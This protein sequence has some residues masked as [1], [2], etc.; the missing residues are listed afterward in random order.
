MKAHVFV[1]LKF[2]LVVFMVLFLLPINVYSQDLPEIKAAGVL[3]HLGIPYANFVTGSGDG[4]DIEVIKGFATYLGVDYQF[5]ESDWS[6]IF[7]DLTG[8]HAQRGENGTQLLGTAKI[9]GDIIA[10][11]M[12][13][14]PWRQ[15]V[16]NFSNPTFPSAVWLVARAESTLTPIKPTGSVLTDI[17][18]VKRSLEGYS[19]LTLKNTCLD[20]ALYQL[21]ETR[22]DVR[23]PDEKLKLNEMAPAILNQE[24]ETTLLDVPDALIALEKWP[25]Q[26]KVIGPISGQQV[27]GAGFRKN[28]PQLLEAFN[29]YLKIIKNDGTY[30]KL[31]KKY[32]PSVFI[33]YADFF[34]Q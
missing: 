8:R 34:N 22:A 25:G 24:A 6:H 10:N 1:K 17:S 26:L 32:Y 15:N 4:L 9:K 31:V 11:G 18:L 7:G 27:M 14:L 5:I 16:I 12:T 30:N 29:H 21:S 20:P 3:R 28:S 23:S 13:V 33:Y 19:V 2:L